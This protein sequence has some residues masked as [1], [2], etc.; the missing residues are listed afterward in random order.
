LHLNLMN[1][2]ILDNNPLSPLFLTLVVIFVLMM[3]V[4]ATQSQRTWCA[5][6]L[7]Y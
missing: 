2:T 3:S 4:Q 5:T 7:E 1:R 6:L